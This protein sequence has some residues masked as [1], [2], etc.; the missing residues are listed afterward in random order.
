VTNSALAKPV[1]VTL[2]LITLAR[3]KGQRPEN[4]DTCGFYC[5]SL[6]KADAGSVPCSTTNTQS[7]NPYRLG[8]FLPVPP[9]K[10][11]LGVAS[12]TPA[13]ARFSPRFPQIPLSVIS[14]D[15]SARDATLFIFND[16]QAAS[17]ISNLVGRWGMKTQNE[18]KSLPNFELSHRSP[19]ARPLRSG[20]PP[21]LVKSAE[22][23]NLY[24]S[25]LACGLIN[26]CS[27]DELGSR[28]NQ[29]R[30]Q[31]CPCAA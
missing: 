1:R 26:S 20:T 3:E 7:P 13:T 9:V 27:F 5:Y 23:N 29:M 10:T 25:M 15:A 19:L 22:M 30:R 24:K 14:R 17:S 28:E 12:V 6:R 31:I 8:F 2:Q 11:A 21:K 16:L 18:P 4:T